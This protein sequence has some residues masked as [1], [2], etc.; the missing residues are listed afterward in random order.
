MTFYNNDL[1]RIGHALKDKNK[2]AATFTLS[3]AINYLCGRPVLNTY[4]NLAGR[5]KKVWDQ[6]FP[7]EKQLGG[8]M[9]ER[10]FHE[11]YG[12]KL[13][14]VG[15]EYQRSI[16]SLSNSEYAMRFYQ[17]L[18]RGNLE[19]TV[20]V[21]K[22][23]QEVPYYVTPN[24]SAGYFDIFTK[25]SADAKPLTPEQQAERGFI[26]E[27][28]AQ[29]VRERLNQMESNKHAQKQGEVLEKVS[30]KLPE[31][32][33]NA[34]MHKQEKVSESSPDGS[35]NT[36]NHRQR[37]NVGGENKNSENLSGGNGSVKKKNKPKIS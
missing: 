9:K 26:S 31:G 29:K 24:I 18:E 23:G 3:R 11:E 1:K 6:A 32:S 2:L 19:K 36:K 12:F 20:F 30:E 27:E 35:T 37:K 4:K 22:T 33:V 17:S 16:K 10:S 7:H 21:E 8:K 25:C 14:A 28:F 13:R 34:K 15:S 5:I